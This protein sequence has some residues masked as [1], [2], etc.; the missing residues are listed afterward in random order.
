MDRLTDNGENI[1]TFILKFFY[2]YVGIYVQMHPFHLVKD[3]T[4]SLFTTYEVIGELIQ[5][6]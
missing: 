1:P 3:D 2:F 4:N 6:L 5:K